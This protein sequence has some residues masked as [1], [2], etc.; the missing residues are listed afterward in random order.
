MDDLNKKFGF[1]KNPEEMS[2][3][4]GQIDRVTFVN[5]E[6]GY[7]VAK[8]SV[9]GYAEPVTIVGRLLSLAP[10]E[11]L[12]ME[13]AWKNHPKFGRQFHV[14]NH[15]SILPAT[16]RGIR[17]YLGSG[18][19][20]GVGPVMASRIV[21]KF[22]ER[23]LD[24]IDNHIHKLAEIDGIGP[25]RVDMI[26]KAWAEQKEIRSIMIFLQEHGV[27]PGHAAKIYK[28]YG[29]RAVAVVS[30]NP[31][32][33]ATDISGIGFRTA[34]RIAQRL[35]FEKNAPMRA[36]AGIL[37]VLGQLTSEGHV[38][39]PY[40]RL[41][42]MCGEVLELDRETLVRAFG[43][44]ALE[45]RIVVEDLNEALEGFEPNLKAVY[46]AALH[47]SETGVAAHLNRLI[48][49]KKGVRRMD[50]DKALQWV[51]GRINLRLGALQVEAVKRSIQEKV[52]AI[53][54]GPGTGKTTI[55]QA[56]IQIYG[57]VGARIELAAPT[58]RAAKRM[59]ETT[60]RVA[61][62]IHRML[63]VSWRQGGFQRNEDRPVDADMVIV[64]EASMID[65]PLMYHLLKA[66]PPGVTL[67][68]VGDAHQLPSVGPGN[69]LGDIIRSGSIPVVEL[70]EVFRQASESLIIVNAHRINRG[71]LPE[72]A[73]SQGDLR[74]FYFIEQDDPDSALQLIKELVGKRIPERFAM[75]PMKDIQGLS[76]MHKGVVGTLNLNAVLQD[77]LNPSGSGIVR[78]ERQYRLNDRVMQIRNNYEREVFNG[79]IGLIRSLDLEKQE[80]IVAY[81]D[82]P[83]VYS[84]M[85]LDEIVLAYA[86][87][88]HQSQGS[89]YPAV[90]LPL[91]PQHYMMLQRNLIYTA[92]TRGKR[93]VIVVGSKRALAMGVKN[94]R[95]AKRY[96]YLAERLRAF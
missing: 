30:Q 89:E 10:G 77:E 35:G 7:T 79:D 28:Q 34:D 6:T 67:L 87:S 66:M 37:H 74:D 22:G 78:G 51:N 63:E 32:R 50:A 17:N 27:G 85:D 58:G 95:V 81:E 55:I 8:A 83:V 19:V 49:S 88:V 18:L 82:R 90:V 9:D 4:T 71:L 40:E 61:R 36:E 54:G 72:G 1:P 92:V 76:P 96:T 57:A 56:V 69:V 94:D 73:D 31:Y 93:L 39:Y 15:R 62:T 24:I 48:S 53:T 65:T 2:A 42:D 13:G 68:M 16:I 14:L 70:K 20:R 5:E 52:L 47:V 11:I 91:F 12:E 43:A 21:K 80:M 86:V 84:F 33:L 60:G 25:K 29:Q 45:G 41:V 26:R 3:L 64:D 44:I 23:T 75:N 59:M 46:P 38:H